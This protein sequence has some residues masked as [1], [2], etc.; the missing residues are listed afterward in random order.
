MISRRTL[1]IAATIGPALVTLGIG[2]F[3]L[4]ALARLGAARDAVS[5]SR[6]ITES[7]QTVLTRLTDAETSQ[8]GYLL[9]GSRD[10][11]VPGA[12]AASDVHGALA[13]ARRLIEDS[14]E[15]RRVDTLSSA[16]AEKLAELDEATRAYDSGGLVAAA[17]IVRSGHGEALMRE[18][19]E[20]VGKIEGAERA[21]L[22]LREAHESR[23][24]II[25]AALI[26]AAILLAGMLS[27]LV[28][29]MLG[30]ALAAREAA[31]ERRVRALAELETV[32]R[33]LNAQALEMQAQTVELEQANEELHG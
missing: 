6:D 33:E 4:A 27:L 24:R 31:D 8:R 11:L 14:I 9:T 17:V 20:Q 23:L 30:R 7:L 28:N 26:F 16:I 18:V 25:T 22:E 13:S 2:I 32:N 12:G 1:R 19:R 10:Y 21:R 3:S 29:T 15:Q 5:H